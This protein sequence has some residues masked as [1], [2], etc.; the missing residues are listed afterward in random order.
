MKQITAMLAVFGLGAGMATAGAMA[1]GELDFGE[2]GQ[3]AAALTDTAPD[4]ENGAAVMVDRGKGNCIAC[5]AVTALEDSPWHGEVG[6]MLDGVGDRW[7]AED[8]RG[9]LVNAKNVFPGTVMP[10]YYKNSGFVRP[11]D[12]YTGNAASGEIPTVLTAQEV[13]DV[14]AFLQTLK[15]ED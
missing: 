6:P 9:I 14:V 8:L 12:G 15:Y 5:H 4:P 2:Y 10:A 1:P 7:S 13:E 11:G 3:V